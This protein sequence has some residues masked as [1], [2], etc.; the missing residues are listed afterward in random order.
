MRNI[1]KIVIL[2]VLCLSISSCKKES[3]CIE[4]KIKSIKSENVWNPPAKIWSYKYNGQIVYFIPQRCCDIPSVLLDE[5]CNPICSPDG[6]FTGK[7][8]GRC[9][10]FFDKRTN[11]KL[12]WKD[13]RTYP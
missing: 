11:K 7:G 13:K 10:D 2:V 12:I 8:D 6:G 1:S 9:S 5:N 4:E 3:A